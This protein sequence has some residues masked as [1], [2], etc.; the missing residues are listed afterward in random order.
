MLLVTNVLIPNVN[1]I[2]VCNNAKIK[3]R[4]DNQST[5]DVPEIK[6]GIANTT[7]ALYIHIPGTLN[8]TC[9]C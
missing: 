3:L 6:L 2:F 5:T 4:I 8:T 1:S 9:T 7:P